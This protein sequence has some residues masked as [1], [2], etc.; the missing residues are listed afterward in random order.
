MDYYTFWIM[1]NSGLERWGTIENLY[2]ALYRLYCLIGY[3]PIML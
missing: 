2:K 3:R 1:L